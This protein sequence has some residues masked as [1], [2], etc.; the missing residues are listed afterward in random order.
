MKKFIKFYIWF[1]MLVGIWGVVMILGKESSVL[2]I[3]RNTLFW[4]L[5]PIGVFLYI[6]GKKWLPTFFWK[7]YFFL[8]IADVVYDF[9]YMKKFEVQPVGSSEIAYL[10]SWLFG[11]LF[12][13]P[14]MI[15]IYQ[16]AFTKNS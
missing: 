12:V 3:L 14:V 2:E 6:N 13:V 10:L 4:V 8:M 15:T 7:S 1:Y 11:A 5:G 9:F 16:Y